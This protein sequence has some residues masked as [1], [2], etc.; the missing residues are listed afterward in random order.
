MT[1]TDRS[2]KK[3]QITGDPVG[4]V[5]QKYN[6]RELVAKMPKDYPVEELDWGNPTGKEIW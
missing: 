2:Q 1:S 4:K 6:L 5:R 3:S